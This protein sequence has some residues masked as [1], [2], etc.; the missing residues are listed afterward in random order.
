VERTFSED[1]AVATK[2][3]KQKKEGFKKICRNSRKRA[4]MRQRVYVKKN[5]R[6]IAKCRRISL[7]HQA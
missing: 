1:L 2:K 6:E 3:A 7:V 5:L 4:I